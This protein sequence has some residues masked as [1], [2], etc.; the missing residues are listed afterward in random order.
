M[1]FVCNDCGGINGQTYAMFAV[2]FENNGSSPIYI[3]AGAGSL[4]AYPYGVGSGDVLLYG[5]GSVL[6]AV[7]ANGCPR[8]LNVVP[9]QEGQNY[10]LYGSGCNTGFYYQVVPSYQ[11]VESGYVDVVLTFQ[12]TMSNNTST[13]N[14][15]TV[16]AAHFIFP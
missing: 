16:I 15:V 6:Q 8:T 13:F 11:D 4:N 2:N 1:E 3:A 10:T 9:L 14:G 7:P 5:E 12:W